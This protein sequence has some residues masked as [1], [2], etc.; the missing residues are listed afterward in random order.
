MELAR[1]TASQRSK[2]ADFYPPEF[3][4]MGFSRVA[5]LH[6]APLLARLVLCAAF[7]PIGW[8]KIMTVETY[9]GPGVATIRAM[10]ADPLSTPDVPDLAQASPSTESVEV[11]RV[12]ELAV[13][14][15]EHR[16]PAPAIAAW[17]VAITELVGGGLL[18][19]GLLSRIWAFGLATAMGL[20]FTI[21]SWPIIAASSPWE[22]GVFELDLP[23]YLR[24][25][26]Q[27]GLGTLAL[28]VLLTGPGAIAIDHAIFSRRT[29]AKASTSQDSWDA[30]D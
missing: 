3:T 8:Q 6:F 2:T 4:S 28:I 18:L 7:I 19:V 26:S 14:L 11:R 16:I 5:A 25:T 17:V 27:L 22:L 29:P 13:M 10:Q 23:D 30:E 24:A 20:A 15:A 1:T 21:T 9:T 12:Y